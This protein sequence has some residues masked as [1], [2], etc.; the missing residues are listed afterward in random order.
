MVRNINQRDYIRELWGSVSQ[1]WIS[2]LVRTSFAPRSDIVNKSRFVFC[3]GPQATQPKK[4][5]AK[6]DDMK[7]TCLSDQRC[8]MGKWIM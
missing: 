5:N 2:D 3:R 7:M 4:P 1:I 8:A 6:E